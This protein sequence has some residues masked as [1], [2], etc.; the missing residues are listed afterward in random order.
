MSQQYFPVILI[1]ALYEVV[2]FLEYDHSN[3]LRTEQYFPV[4]LF[5]IPY[6]VV[7]TLKSVDQ[8]LKCDHSNDRYRA[9][10]SFQRGRAIYYAVH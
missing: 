7:L 8:I 10:Y 1:I 3:E 5:I 4:M 6:Q 2:N 9:V